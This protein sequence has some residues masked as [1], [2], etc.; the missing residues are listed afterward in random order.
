MAWNFCKGKAIH[1]QIADRIA[2][3][4]LTGA[5]L[6]TQRMPSVEDMSR[7]TGASVQ[8]VAKAYDEIV[9]CGIAQLHGGLLI[10]SEDMS[11]ARLRRD[12]L[13]VEAT[14]RYIRDMEEIGLSRK[15]VLGIL[16]TSLV[17]RSKAEENGKN[18]TVKE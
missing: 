9:S 17:K 14:E 18:R 2:I 6:P 1:S 10:V 7:I 5:I 8:I 13:A 15:E 12:E 16:G 11:A 4:V 3:D